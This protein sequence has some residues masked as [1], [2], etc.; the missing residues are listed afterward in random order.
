M[1]T[2]HNIR[3]VKLGN[4]FVFMTG[5]DTNLGRPFHRINIYYRYVHTVKSCVVYISSTL[6]GE[7]QRLVVLHRRNSTY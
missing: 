2:K 7:R 1:D 5:S 4:F 6:T 3:R